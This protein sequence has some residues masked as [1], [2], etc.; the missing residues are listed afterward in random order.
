MLKL[1]VISLAA[2]AFSGSVFAADLPFPVKAAPPPAP[3]PAYSWTGFYV[4]ANLGGGWASRNVDYTPNDP[5]TALLL[6]ALGSPSE[7][8]N[9]SG[10]IGGLQLGYNKQFNRNW[11]VGLETD[12]DGSGMKGSGSS[13][14]FAGFITESV[15]ERVDWFGTVRARLGYLPTSN[16]LAYFTG[17]FAY[18]RVDHSGNLSIPG[19]ILLINTPPFSTTCTGPAVCSA[20][21]SSGVDVGW[22]VGGGLEYALSQNF[23]VKA[24]YLYVSLQGR[25]VTE[26]ALAVFIPGTIPNSFNA[27]FGRTN[28]N[29]ARVGFDYR[30]Q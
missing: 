30:F 7:S 15:A 28:F 26:T 2:L 14:Q 22:T 25:S 27:N 24:D 18:G 17:G 9:T 29:V 16:L 23:S 10:L 5:G 11:L 19:G 6:A 13:S 4:G 8:F 1:G 21:S 20:G 12:I 3:A